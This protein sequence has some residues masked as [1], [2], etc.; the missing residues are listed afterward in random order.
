MY[1]EGLLHEESMVFGANNVMDLF[2]A[3]LGSMIRDFRIIE[4]KKG[5][6]HYE[7]IP[8]DLVV[9]FNNIFEYYFTGKLPDEL[10]Y[11]TLD[12]KDILKP[13]L[14]TV[15]DYCLSKFE[16]FKELT[17]GYDE[18]IVCEVYLLLS[19]SLLFRHQNIGRVQAETSND[20]EEISR[21]INDM[22]EQK[23]LIGLYSDQ[24]NVST[25][26]IRYCLNFI[27]KVKNFS[28]GGETQPRRFLL[29]FQYSGTGNSGFF[30]PLLLQI[31]ST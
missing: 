19:N 6:Q 17:Q 23:I 26:F 29:S 27:L 16:L 1:L 25:K 18:L 4:E 20:L 28:Q 3:L 10:K 12:Q 31:R 30:S 22:V 7:E 9:K 11:M 14:S 8:L 5:T 21:N 24:R 2:R 13:L 15:W